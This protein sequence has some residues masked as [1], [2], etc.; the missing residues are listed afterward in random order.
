MSN[1]KTWGRIIRNIEETG[2]YYERVNKVISLG[3]GDKLRY[4]ACR[5]IVDGNILDAGA[6]SGLLTYRILASKNDVYVIGLDASY[7]LLKSSLN[8]L[9]IFLDR[10]D[11]VV[12]IF[13]SPPFRDGSLD[14]VYTAYAVRDSINHLEAIRNLSKVIR[15]SG[16][17]IDVDIGNPDNRIISAIL[18]IYIK[19]MVPLIAALI[20]KNVFNPWCSL[21]ETIHRTPSNRELILIC[22]KFFKKVLFKK[23][24]ASMLY[25]LKCLK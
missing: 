14:A 18:R 20:S 3:Y 17:F 15:D 2:A 22:R 4:L 6:G 12:G 19:Y 9:K 1:L 13:E 5:E 23:Y 11:A 25:L 7:S 24:A 10:Y 16:V 21:I 8:N